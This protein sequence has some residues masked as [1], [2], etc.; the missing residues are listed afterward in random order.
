MNTL[1]STTK[2][3]VAETAERAVN[4]CAH[5]LCD[6]GHCCKLG[7]ALVLQLMEHRCGVVVSR[8]SK[9]H[10]LYNP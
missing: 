1:C 6:N 8:I 4:H 9:C 3:E 2:G 7:D 10:D 5:D